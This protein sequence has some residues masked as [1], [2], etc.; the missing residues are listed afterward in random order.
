M[1]SV[2]DYNSAAPSDYETKPSS[3]RVEATAL[4]IEEEYNGPNAKGKKRGESSGWKEEEGM[5][6]TWKDVW[7]NASVGKNESKSILQGLKTFI[8]WFNLL[9]VRSTWT[10]YVF[11]ITSKRKFT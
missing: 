2:V 1:A 11:S 3:S 9:E 6:L 8:V 4:E 10:S 5:C 7:V